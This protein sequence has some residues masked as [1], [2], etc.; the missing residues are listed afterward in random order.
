MENQGNAAETGKTETAPAAGAPA[1]DAG[2]QNTKSRKFKIGQQVLFHVKYLHGLQGVIVA[3]SNQ[4]E[5]QNIVRG[6]EEAIEGQLFQFSDDDLVSVNEAN[7]G[8]HAETAKE[9][10]DV[11]H[12]SKVD[13]GSR[14]PWDYPQP[15]AAG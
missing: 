11:E 15:E 7:K 9:Q 6:A 10:A 2:K 12:I 4:D 14:L 13:P 5:G 8:E 1:K 3:F